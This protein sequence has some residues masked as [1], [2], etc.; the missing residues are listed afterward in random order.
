MPI[1]CL[2]RSIRQA[3]NVGDRSSSCVAIMKLVHESNI[4]NAITPTSIVNQH[5]EGSKMHYLTHCSLIIGVL[6]KHTTP[7]AVVST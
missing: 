5:T 7:I 3:G 1:M 2:L 6:S 4:I